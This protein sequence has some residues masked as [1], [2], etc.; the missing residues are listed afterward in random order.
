MV[1]SK[2][3]TPVINVVGKY[4]MELYKNPVRTKAITSSIISALGN[5]TS[6]AITGCEINQ[7]SIAAFGLFGLLFGGTI[8]HYFYI[9]LEQAF[10]GSG[11]LTGICKFIVERFIYAP[12]YQMF[13]L[14]V[15]AR[16]EGKSHI[17]AY[18]QTAKLYWSVLQANWQYLSWIQLINILLVPSMFRVLVMNM[19]GFF[20]NIYLASKRRAEN[21]SD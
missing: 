20:W 9:I 1:L 13:S 15:L 17:R 21:K 11:R 14:Y 3:P 18:K 5:Y 19:V 12:L 6:Q 16:F 2:L 8:P 4:L 7:R 10:P